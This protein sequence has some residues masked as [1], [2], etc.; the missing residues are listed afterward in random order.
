MAV[1]P[2]LLEEGAAG[3]ESGAEEATEPGGGWRAV[4]QA[5]GQL[6]RA[7]GAARSVYGSV[8]TPS[9]AAQTVTK[10]L[11]AVALGLIVLEIAAQATGQTWS[12]SL[13]N[14]SAQKP[15]KGAYVPLYAGQQSVAEA[16]PNILGGT[17][18][19]V[20]NAANQAGQAGS[21]IGQATITGVRSILGGMG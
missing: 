3:A 9:A 21:A 12:F 16:F 1:A 18:G 2:E 19:A 13:P 7:P 4:S 15:Q 5:S 8:S 6:R 14:P 11:W 10:L 17:Q 20:T